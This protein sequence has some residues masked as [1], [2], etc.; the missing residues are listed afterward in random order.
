MLTES[1]SFNLS[2]PPDHHNDRQH[3]NN[4]PASNI[5]TKSSTCSNAGH[6]SLKEPTSPQTQKPRAKQILEEEE[7]PST[8]TESSSPSSPTSTVNVD[9]LFVRPP[10]SPWINKTYS[11]S[12]EGLDDELNDLY[13]YLQPTKAERIVRV[14]IFNHV[15]STIQAV[16][17]SCEVSTFGSMATDLFLPF[18][19][20]DIVCFQNSNNK[21]PDPLIRTSEA[22]RDH[23]SLEVVKIIE[24][25]TVPIIKLRDKAT[26]IMID[27]S[28]ETHNALP[29][30]H[31]LLN[32]KQRNPKLSALVLILKQL[33][34]D[35][36]LN[37]NTDG[38]LS[39]Y[40][41][42][43]LVIRLLQ[44]VPEQQCFTETTSN[45]Q[46]SLG[47]LFLSFLKQFG[48]EFDY[49]QYAIRVQEPGAFVHKEELYAQHMSKDVLDHSLLCIED[50]IMLNNDVCNK[51]YKFAAIRNL[52]RDMYINFIDIFNDGFPQQEQQNKEVISSF[53][54]KYIS[55]RNCTPEFRAVVEHVDIPLNSA[56]S[57][58]EVGAVPPTFMPQKDSPFPSYAFPVAAHIYNQYGGYQIVPLVHHIPMNGYQVPINLV[59]FYNAQ[60]QQLNYNRSSP[61]GQGPQQ[62]YQGHFIM[63]YPGLFFHPLLNNTNNNPFNANSNGYQNSPP[64]GQSIL[65]TTSETEPTDDKD[66]LSNS[67]SESESGK[68][69]DL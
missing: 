1:A 2:T 29:T 7:V 13:H 68:E 59:P 9:T 31:F 10:N 36:V 24:K 45:E 62:M 52:W 19:D 39:S 25:A 46:L 5:A 4:H 30:I 64:N 67:N 26:K 14:Q 28:F 42:V 51:S 12:I 57:L 66:T 48:I 8:S 43:L 35:Q 47:N 65:T 38:G 17:P 69:N 18:S 27:V 37:A 55:L 20:I 56:E 15:R 33:L 6:I 21:M 32:F 50:P 11:S 23:E 49:D 40:A 3:S 60:Q 41:I 16:F 53:F 63:P 34:Q 54:V 44:I 61:P 22:F 58:Y